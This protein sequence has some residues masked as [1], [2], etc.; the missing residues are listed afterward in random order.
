MDTTV[1][2]FSLNSG[3]GLSTVH[4]HIKKATY[5]LAK[6]VELDKFI[7]VSGH[8]SHINRI[9]IQKDGWI[10]AIESYEKS[11]QPDVKSSHGLGIDKA[12]LHINPSFIEDVDLFVELGIAERD[13]GHPMNTQA[14][15]DIDLEVAYKLKKK[16]IMWLPLLEGME[17]KVDT[18]IFDF[19]ERTLKIYVK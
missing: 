6:K 18:I 13:K 11:L 19:N 3:K 16:D 12:K 17:F 7:D 5:L 15:M 2:E 8:W 1:K 10:K 9:R 4:S 14:V